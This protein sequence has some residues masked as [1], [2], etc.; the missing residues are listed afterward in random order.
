MD[1]EAWQATGHRIEKSWTGLGTQHNNAV[2]CDG[3]HSAAERTYPT[4]EVR[5]GGW[6]ELPHV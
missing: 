6:E 2:S 5:G 1:R 3:A 4:F